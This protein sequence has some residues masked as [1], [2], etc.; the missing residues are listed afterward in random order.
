MT[1]IVVL[2]SA[3]LHD[4]LS[5]QKSSALVLN[6]R[7]IFLSARVGKPKVEVGDLLLYPVQFPF[8]Q[9]EEDPSA[10][11]VSGSKLHFLVMSDV[12]VAERG[13]IENFL[14]LLPVRLREE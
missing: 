9:L 12:A 5:S 6:F 1:H 4:D 11:G 7:Q 3:T 13:T 2:P 14:L 10:R 8:A